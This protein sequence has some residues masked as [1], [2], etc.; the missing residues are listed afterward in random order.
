MAIQMSKDYKSF[1]CSEGYFKITT[2]ADVFYNTNRININVGFWKDKASREAGDE[3]LEM[4]SFSTDNISIIDSPNDGTR[5][6]LYTY[7]KT[8]DFFE[9]AIDA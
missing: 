3:M 1:V 6:A 2:S 5:T 9:G 7:L 8:L 4:F